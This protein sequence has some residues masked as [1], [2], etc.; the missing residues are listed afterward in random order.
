MSTVCQRCVQTSGA[1]AEHF[2]TPGM[3]LDISGKPR[4]DAYAVMRCE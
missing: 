3:Y 4:S 1:N 2:L